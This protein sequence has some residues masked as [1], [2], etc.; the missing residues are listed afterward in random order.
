MT[1][2]NCK[3]SKGKIISEWITG[4]EARDKEKE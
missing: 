2:E 4:D 3:F 1:G